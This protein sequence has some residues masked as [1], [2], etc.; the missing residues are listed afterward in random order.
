M[1]PLIKLAKKLKEEYVIT[2]DEFLAS[3]PLI[4][5]AKKLK[6]EEVWFNYGRESF[7]LI[8]LAKKLKVLGYFLRLAQI[9]TFPL[10]KLAKKLKVW[11]FVFLGLLAI[12]SIN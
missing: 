4:K 2:T 3:F 11:V 9:N 10:I 5:L 12:V 8:K 7:P 6:G 1:F